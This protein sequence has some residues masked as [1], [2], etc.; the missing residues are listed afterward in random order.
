MRIGWATKLKKMCIKNSF[1][2]PM[3]FTGILFLSSCS[4]TKNLPEGEA[5]YIG[6]KKMQI[7]SLPK[8]QTGHIV[9]E[10]IEAVLSASPNNSLFGSATMRYWPPVGLWIYNR[11]VNAKTKLGKFIF[12][13]LATKPVL[14]STINPDIRVK[15][16]NTLLHDYGYFTGT[17]SYALFPHAKNYSKRRCM[18]YLSDVS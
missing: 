18:N 17:V 16:A 12:D 4:T 1:I 11:Y 3:I 8:T 13:K 10:E 5:L 15:V 2:F 9:W 6:Q 7:D 14:I